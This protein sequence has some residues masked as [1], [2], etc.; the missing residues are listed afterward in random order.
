MFYTLLF[1]LIHF[2]ILIL[3]LVLHVWVVAVYEIFPVIWYLYFYSKKSDALNTRMYTISVIE[4]ILNSI[5]CTYFFGW[6][7]GFHIYL[8]LIPIKSYFIAYHMR[9]HHLGNLRPLP[10]S[11]AAFAAAVILRSYSSRWILPGDVTS[12]TL[13]GFI[14]DM[15]LIIF[16]GAALFLLMAFYSSI[17]EMELVVER[18]NKLLAASAEDLKTKNAD[19]LQSSTTDYLTGL[20]NRRSM[21]PC[22]IHLESQYVQYK[23]PFCAVIGDID[24]FK[25]I[26]DTYGHNSGDDVLIAVTEC[27]SGNLRADDRICRWGGEEF[28]ILLAN[29]DMTKAQTTMERIRNSIKALRI[30]GPDGAIT[31]TITFGVADYNGQE[32]DQLTHQADEK[33]YYGKRHGKNVVVLSIP[34]LSV[35]EN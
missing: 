28:L 13:H 8:F 26:N 6:S 5:F 11:I 34:E 15:N 1:A 10:Y 17:Q 33:L 27:I 30:P 18:K 12:S 14:Y 16:F 25:K 7:Y 3:A 29:C 20:L 31:C 2:G 21:M 4:V 22:F 9:T 23:T 19:L 24:D 32:F 35:A